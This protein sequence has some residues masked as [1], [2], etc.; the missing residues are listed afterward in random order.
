LQDE[1][2]LEER[3]Y[4]MIGKLAEFVE[5]LAVLNE[6]EGVTKGKFSLSE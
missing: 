6:R 5:F 4:K 1:R 2:I 3:T